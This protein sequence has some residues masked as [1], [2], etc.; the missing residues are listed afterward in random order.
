MT[1]R[2]ESP[3]AEWSPEP[4]RWGYSDLLALLVWTAGVVWIFGKAATLREALFYFDVTEINYPYRDFLAEQIRNGRFARWHPGLY[5]GLPLYSESQAGYW[6][7]LKY[8][9]YPWLPTWKA[10]NLDTILSVWLTGVGAFGWLRR[11]VG[12]AGAF[13][14]AVVCGLGG[15]TWAHLIHTSMMNAL[16][17]VPLAFWA[18]EASWTSGRLR[19]AA[20]GG[21][22]IACQVFAGHLQDTLLTGSALGVY[23]LARF[24]GARTGR[25]RRQILIAAATLMGLGI[26]A[27]GIQ[28]VPSKEL[29]D[30]S[31]RAGGLSYDDQAYGSWHP[32]LLPTLLVREAYGTLARDTDW[33][34][35]YYPYHEMNAYLGALALG[36]AVV[37]AAAW[38]DRW[39]AGWMVVG[40]VGALL[41]LG[42]YTIVFDLLRRVPVLG[43]SRIAVRY[44]LWMTMAVAALAAVGV[45][46]LA[47]PGRVRL[48]PAL[49]TL[50]VL[51]AISAVLLMA[52]YP[53][54]WTD[55]RNWS[56]SYLGPRSHALIEQLA[57]STARVSALLALGAWAAFRASRATDSRRRRTWA[58]V[59]PLLVMVDLLGSHAW[60]VPTI[61]PAYWTSPPPAVPLI[62]DD[63]H[64][65]RVMGLR[66]KA[67][68][69]P[70][71]LSRPIDFFPVRDTLAWSLPPVWGLRSAWGE[72]PIHDARIDAYADAVSFPRGRFA[73]EGVTHLLAAR[74]FAS[75]D[76]PPPVRAGTANI[77]KIPDSLPRARLV[78]RPVYATDRSSATK[79][80]R[81]IDPRKRLVVEDP[82]R[83]LP[84]TAPDP[85]GVA[86]IT[87]DEP[88]RVDVV[89]DSPSP[90]YLFLADTFDP[91]WSATVDGRPAPIRPAQ[92]AF[93]AVFLTTGRHLVRF[94]YQPAG[95]D[96]G[97]ALT[98]AGGLGVAF[99]MVVPLRL[100]PPTTLS[101]P[102]G[103]PRR[104]PVI[105]LLLLAA[106]L[107]VSIPSVGSGPT[108]RLQSRWTHVVH[109][110]TWGA[111]ISTIKPP[112]RREF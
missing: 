17:S 22:A 59:L 41:M 74:G 81:A 69:E 33:M 53:P 104:W 9:L 5:C 57:G 83:P 112:P 63:P 76:L 98:V 100:S 94:R 45:D 28:W 29:L 48:A 35:G 26:A 60:D 16:P 67:A 10:F 30:R 73:L 23:T 72:T 107:A 65:G 44:H 38:R 27:A 15:F 101:G 93:R 99:L 110:F 80:L 18:L 58:S 89:T 70:G 40:A 49:V 8:L 43:S 2:D 34:D 39:V 79:I 14:G 4:R 20:L 102:S 36:L 77:L 90:S 91:G 42:R 95:W 92:V 109:P 84:M 50:G 82:M 51:I 87:L 12:P 75:R 56:G 55:A 62:R 88:E 13:T 21:L 105:G 78:G 1:C 7:P 64:S 71:Y 61:D 24:A 46:R 103:W 86:T 111:A 54:L 25:E 106:I 85:A 6:H 96:L 11:Q 66:D 47:R 32:E 3:P 68:A 108:L 97:M 31:P 37:G 19:A 52:I